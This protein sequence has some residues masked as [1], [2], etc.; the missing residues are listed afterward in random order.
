MLLIPL[1]AGWAV[2]VFA[3]EKVS[4]AGLIRSADNQEAVA[5]IVSLIEGE[6]ILAFATADAGNGR[7]Q[8]KPLTIDNP[9]ICRLQVSALGYQKRLLPLDSLRNLG[10]L[11][12]ELLSSSFSVKEVVIAESRPS[13][14][15]LDTVSFDPKHYIDSTETTLE[16]VLG[17]LPGVE[18][19]ENGEIEFVGQKVA[20]IL[21]EGD[22]LSG[23]DYQLVS[24]NLPADLV[25][26]VQFVSNYVENQLLRGFD[27]PESL[28]IN[29]QMDQEKIRKPRANIEMGIGT[30]ASN[31]LHFTGMVFG[32]DV[33]LLGNLAYQSIGDALPFQRDNQWDELAD[34][35]KVN[36]P[37][38]HENIGLPS[39]RHQ[40][41]ALPLDFVRDRFNHSGRG[42]IRM[43]ANPS[44]RY[45]MTFA[46]KGSIETVDQSMQM[47]RLYRLPD[48]S[49]QL[50][51]RFNRTDQP[52]GH[53]VSLRQQIELGAASNLSLL[54]GF[55]GSIRH[56]SSQLDLPNNA[57]DME[58]Q[59]RSYRL[60][61]QLAYV[62]RISDKNIFIIDGIYDRGRQNQQLGLISDQL[63]FWENDSIGDIQQTLDLSHLHSGLNLRWLSRWG[64][65]S[66][67]LSMGSSLQTATFNE[68][69]LRQ[70]Q[71]Y[72]RAKLRRQFS[73]GFFIVGDMTLGMYELRRGEAE[74]KTT[75]LWRPLVIPAVITGQENIRFSWLSSYTFNYQAPGLQQLYQ[76]P[77]WNNY[78][79]LQR[80]DST[81]ALSNT[82]NVQASF[83][84]QP[85]LNPVSSFIY[86]VKAGL[87]WGENAYQTRFDLSGNLD[88]L[89]FFQRFQPTRSIRV[90]AGVEK[91]LAPLVTAVKLRPEY[92]QFTYQNQWEDG[93]QRLINSQVFAF[94]FQF[95]TATSSPIDLAVNIKP[96]WN[97]VNV[98][99]NGINSQVNAR[100]VSAY[101]DVFVRFRKNLRLTIRNEYL[102]LNQDGQEGQQYFL[103]EFELLYK[104]S[105]EDKK[106][107]S[108]L[109]LGRNLSNAQ[110]FG[111]NQIGDFV[112]SFSATRIRPRT[113]MLEC[114]FQL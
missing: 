2:S 73:H 33:K 46:L 8:L 80:G 82:H 76:T 9:T 5:G 110:Y 15:S 17:K 95:K 92:Q 27:V 96:G 64:K 97:R 35:T 21:L 32:K 93:T 13:R 107:I 91:F 6:R 24:Q 63:R 20:R 22:D 90:N 67:H 85:N 79:Q 65:V 31:R 78:R 56:L 70:Q 113:I 84:F 77:L 25:N 42:D 105:R 39:F 19:D 1:L 112:S 29:I 59:D 83:R 86:F 69:K 87:N 3:Q 30:A 55:S 101:A 58:T 66:S 16:E 14:Q 34:L 7:F 100:S 36:G 103:S 52:L 45:K 98:R 61:Q 26:R 4:I 43:V 50:Q 104:W 51:E 10:Q 109:L 102:Q 44:P 88:Q 62:K 37:L 48:T 106:D 18:I 74:Q 71:H 47:D 41:V 60:R 38:Q 40:E 57:F 81:L 23:R 114:A 54:T 49:F 94:S 89:S 12:I 11:E 99:Q 111:L 53:H 68:M 28:V 108:F 72:L 75:R